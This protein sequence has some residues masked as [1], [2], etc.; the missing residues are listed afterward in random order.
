MGADTTFGTRTSLWTVVPSEAAPL[1]AAVTIDDEAAAKR[2]A[3]GPQLSGLSCPSSLMS[4]RRTLAWADVK[5]THRRYWYCGEGATEANFNPSNAN[6]RL[7]SR[8]WQLEIGH[9][10]TGQNIN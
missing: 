7:P 4:R 10:L 8:F 1:Q 9:C 6:K 2:K 5:V 3:E